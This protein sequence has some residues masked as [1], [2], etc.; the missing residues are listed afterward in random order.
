MDVGFSCCRLLFF[1]GVL[2]TFSSVRFT[3]AETLSPEAVVKK[4]TKL[5][6]RDTAAAGRLTTDA[7]RGGNPPQVW[8]E[9]TQAF[10]KSFGYQHLG[11][12]ILSSQIS[13][14]NVRIVL[15]ALIASGDGV[16][17]QQETYTLKRV[18]GQWLIDAIDTTDEHR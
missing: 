17:W 4:W 3:H 13:E 14:A 10:L 5:Y 9:R 11:G 18:D 16:S 2:S 6:G 8:G 1:L 7:F 15:Q 12:K